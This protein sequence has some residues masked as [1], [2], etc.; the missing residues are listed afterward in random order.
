M[1][2]KILDLLNRKNKALDI[3]EIFHLLELKREN[4]EELVETINKMINDYTIYQTNKGR[5]MTFDRSPLKKGYLRINKKGY[6]FVD[7]EDEEDIFVESNNLNGAIHNDLVIV[8]VLGRSARHRSEGRILKIL[9]RKLDTVVG[10]F[11]LEN[12]VGHIILDDDKLKIEVSIDSNDINGAVDGSKVLVKLLEQLPGNYKY[13][14]EVIK[15]LGHK[16]DP[17]VDILSI[18]YK[19]NINVDFPEEV[20]E[21]LKSI[22]DSV[23]EEDKVNRR[24]LTNECIFTID[25]DDTKD[26]DDAIS[27]EKLENGNYKLGVHIADVSYYVK[28]GTALDINAMD[29]GTSVYLVDRVIPMIPHQLSNGICSLNEGVERLAVS[30]VMEVDTKGN[31]VDYEIFPSVIKSRK[32]MTYKCVNSILEDNVIPSGYEEFV[33]D[34]KT[35][36]ELSKIVRKNKLNRGYLDFDV[37][38]PKIIVDEKCHPIEIKLRNRGVGEN[39]IEDFMILANECVATHIYY[40]ELPF[41]YRIHEEPKEEKIRDFLGYLSTLGYTYKGNIKDVSP[42]TVQGILE[43]LKDKKEFKILSSLLL[44]S[45]QKAVYREN[46]LGHYGLASKCYTHFTSPIRRY[47]DTT[48]H[49]LLHTYLFD[50]DLSSETIRHWEQK[51][52]VIAEVAS[53]RERASVDCEREVDDMK[54]AEYMEDHIGEEFE[55]MISG[56]TN[57]GIFVELDNLIEGLCRLQDMKDFY[58]F[59]EKT[60]T[61]TGEKTKKTFRMGDRVLVKVVRASKD[62]ATIDFDIIKKVDDK[63]K[64]DDIEVI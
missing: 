1:E 17:G 58:H 48:V 45:M 4:Y 35:M 18:V 29:R 38:E 56:I 22:P 54:M 25:G 28:E 60:M 30:C 12:N 33:D 53:A 37:D 26:I 8:E 36:F 55:G 2:D 62:D 39:L 52:P 46:N 40:M 49:R 34:L 41:I 24:D 14:G 59:D 15:V 51:L 32:K 9:E 10:E 27:I 20:E 11:Y 44:R 6:G 23:R 13:K 57:F 50:N 16:N 7:L 21:E 61:A 47:P 42:K 64:V 5:Y 63:E 31:T 43:F 19:Y 3:D